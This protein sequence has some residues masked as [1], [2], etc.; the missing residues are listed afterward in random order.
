[1]SKHKQRASRSYTA[2][3]PRR[4]FQSHRKSSFEILESRLPLAVFT[5]TTASDT[6]NPGDGVTS[7]R[8]AIASAAASSGF[9]SI[10]FNISGSTTIQ[11]TSPL[12]TISSQVEIR[13]DSQPGYAGTPVVELNGAS[14]GANA[15]GFKFTSSG[16]TVRGLAINRFNGN[17]MH[18]LLSSGNTVV[19]NYI[20]TDLSGTIDLGNAKDGIFIDGGTGNV[21]GGL[22]SADRNLI[23]GNNFSGIF[24]NASSGV[25]IRGNYIGTNASG[26][27]DLGNSRDGI[28]LLDTPNGSVGGTQVAARNVISGNNQNGVVVF[29]AAATNNSISGNYIGTSAAGDQA[30]GNSIVGV[31]VTG[32]SGGGGTASQNT[33]GGTAV[34]AGNVISG[35]IRNG[36]EFF[37]GVHNNKVQGNFI[38]TAADGSAAL[39]NGGAGVDPLGGFGIVVDQSPNN[40]IGGDDD[41][42]GIPDGIIHARNVVSGNM[43]GGV[44]IGGTGTSGVAVA[45]NFI[46]LNAIGAAAL[47]NGGPGLLVEAVSNNTVGG[48]TPGAGN[49]ISGNA[50][51]GVELR[52]RASNNYL[53]GNRIGTD[54]AGMRAVGNGGD[55]IQLNESFN[56]SIGDYT[57]TP[58]TLPGN[59]V[60]G[61]AGS[62]IHLVGAAATL[63]TVQGNIIGLDAA[64]IGWIPNEMHGVHIESAQFNT[65]GAESV[66][67]LHGRNILSGNT[68]DGVRIDGSNA[69]GNHIVANWIGLTLTGV[70][71]HGNQGSGVSI[72]QSQANVVALGNVISGNLAHGVEIVGTD[73]SANHVTGNTIGL[74]VAGIG[75]VGNQIY[76]VLIQD[77][78]HNVIGGALAPGG[79]SLGNVISANGQV[80]VQISGESA[81]FNM[82]QGNLI[83]TTADGTIDRGN[84]KHGVVVWDANNNSIGGSTDG[85][86]NTIAFNGAALNLQGHGVLIFAGAANSIRRNSIHSNRGRG[87]DLGSDSFN[88][89]DFDDADTGANDLQNAPYVSKVV[90]AVA[91]KLIEFS[92]RSTPLTDFVWD[93]YANSE[94]DPSGFGEGR[95]LLLSTNAPT[96]SNGLAIVSVTTSITNLYV[97]ATVTDPAGNTSEFSMVDTD[98]DALADAWEPFGI[99][100]DEDGAIDLFLPGANA[101]KKDLFIEVDA[102]VGLNPMTDALN[103]VVTA[104]AAAPAESVKNPDGSVGI[105]LHWIHGGDWS[106][107]RQ[108]WN[109]VSALGYPLA[110]SRVKDGDPNGD[111]SDGAFGLPTERLSTNWSNIRASR[112]LVYRYAVFADSFG[113]SGASGIAELPGNDFI[114]TLGSQWRTD[115]GTRSEQAGTF[116]HELG[117]TLGLGHGGGNSMQFKPNY[118]SVM[119]YIWQLPGA[120]YVGSWKLDY[121]RK[122]LASIDESAVSESAGF[123]G[124]PGKVVPVGPVFNTAT[125]GRTALR[126]VAQSGA[127]DLNANGNTSDTLSV[128]LNFHTDVNGDF[129]I[130]ALDASPNE[131]LV[132]YDDWS[133][134]VYRL[135]ESAIFQFG[136]NR[137]TLD[138]FMLLDSLGSGPGVFQ[139]AR[140]QTAVEERRG[141]ATI[142][143]ARAGGTDGPVSVQYQ[144]VLGGSAAL[145]GDYLATS[146]TLNFADGEYLKTFTVPIIND[147]DA[148]GTET[149]ELL[150]SNPVGATL[151]LRSAA[152]L[153]ITEPMLIGFADVPD[154]EAYESAGAVSIYL[155]LSGEMGQTLS[156]DVVVK[157]SDLLDGTAIAGVHYVASDPFTVTF[158]A[159]STVGTTKSVELY[160]FDNSD[161]GPSRTI[162]LGIRPVDSFAAVADDAE[163]LLTIMDDD[164]APE[165]VGD[166]NPG[167]GS[168]SPNG[169]IDVNG[170][171]F[172]FTDGSGGN[173]T[174]WTTDSTGNAIQVATVPLTNNFQQIVAVGNLLFFMHTDTASQTMQLWRSDGTASGTFKVG[175]FDGGQYHSI[176]SLE[177]VAFNGELFF[178]GSINDLQGVELWKSNGTVAGT[179]LV[180]D[181][182]TNQLNTVN[183]LLAAKGS[184]PNSFAIFNGQLYF[185]A[186]WFYPTMANQS[187]NMYT[188]DTELWRTNGT[189]SGTEL[190]LD[191]VPGDWRFGGPLGQLTAAGP[192]L[193]FVYFTHA[194]GTE[195]YKTQGTAATTER[196]T[197]LDQ[198]GYAGIPRSLT[199]IGNRLF[200]RMSDFPNAQTA[201][202]WSTNGTTD[203]TVKLATKPYL[204]LVEFGGLAYYAIKNGS[205]V[206]I[207]RS[208]GTTAGT[209]MVTTTGTDVT[210][211]EVAVLNGKIYFASNAS[212]TGK[213]LW[214]LSNT[215]GL[216]RVIDLNPGVSGS[217]PLQLRIAKGNLYFTA[218]DGTHGRE[219][220]VIDF[221]AVPTDAPAEYGDV[222]GD[223]NVDAADYTIWRDN[224]NTAVEPYTRGDIDGDGFVDQADY[225][226]WQ[227]NFG[228]SLPT[229][230]S[231]GSA[232]ALAFSSPV[233]E[234]SEAVTPLASRDAT[235]PMGLSAFAARAGSSASLEIVTQ[236]SALA[237]LRGRLKPVPVTEFTDNDLLLLARDRSPCFVWQSSSV[238]DDNGINDAPSADPE[239]Q[240]VDCE[241]VDLALAEW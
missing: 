215:V 1:M 197:N 28:V 155:Q 63:N 133:N 212:A 94:P 3:S 93:F 180:K 44:W 199:G 32:V 81:T 234:I 78:S 152:T 8:E 96:L 49:V 25:Q 61:N 58:G 35:N 71:P 140:T 65:I 147:P 34:G 207:Y 53:H 211:D 174:L 233:L 29:G 88:L 213:E 219:L 241:L 66:A 236:R 6:V 128:D 158:A 220:Y 162:H 135:N 67:G 42:D 92:L 169:M 167:P 232:R 202:T 33:I 11:L 164:L 68:L 50:G 163:L 204:W 114:V 181:I 112:Q 223:L 217:D 85:E 115:G 230:A 36:I 60:S 79:S 209:W 107:R 238:V 153:E 57:P 9:D 198:F 222:N 136:D 221:D 74:D 203:G 137:V 125:M 173:S 160:F 16:N 159:G 171:L 195:V 82:L 134:L 101:N 193:Y 70:T 150:L 30:L 196:L 183:G 39:G 97:S 18:F 240:D 156:E 105:S 77:A 21:I 108:P 144:T 143:V 40:T 190:A 154:V 110:F 17:G 48:Q 15:D 62:G 117:H 239:S 118:F 104:F 119:N 235:E 148:E 200:F 151:G 45:G 116:M 46:G 31:L 146:G 83:G 38:G 131:R 170:I 95:T 132:G 19:G 90:F 192:S 186:T 73:A 20:G 206:E 2:S 55:G 229:P 149:I 227:M 86:G 225:G 22:S 224:L 106:L 187:P 43:R 168:S 54:S 12:P 189:A 100:I 166:L 87:I 188:F 141:L 210:L 228:L 23:S 99:D 13:G 139:F 165:S 226:L 111:H 113:G 130:D 102:M 64:G 208:D 4:P 120:G 98:G 127:V 216:Q 179:T 178:A 47:A 75:P 205:S 84:A 80:G 218:D 214:S 124:D 24:V 185:F 231:G 142:T 26:N 126:L 184:L 52:N 109:D 69:T 157:I 121:S 14:A 161:K 91:T 122:E 194:F 176:D 76:G 123:G 5:V 59:L 177:M 72:N 103:D 7:L 129:A 89:N 138:Y 37:G 27:A 191:I 56:N 51:S 145:G 175:D 182:N 201:G 172:F 10:H 41:D 237:R